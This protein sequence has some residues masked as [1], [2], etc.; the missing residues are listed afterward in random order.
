MSNPG[1]ASRTSMQASSVTDLRAVT[2]FVDAAG[3][4]AGLDADAMFDLRLAVEEIFVN[5]VHHGYLDQPGPVDVCI[6]TDTDQLAVTLSD[7]A[8]L[9]DPASAPVPNVDAP[10]EERQPG[11]LGWHLVRQLMDEVSHAPRAQGGNTVT[12][13][14]RSRHDDSSN[15]E[16]PRNAD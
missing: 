4:R 16:V 7:R 3:A 15:P 10:L 8:P 9:F 12:L 13:V 1:A 14:K 5:I 11:G 6:T 2:A